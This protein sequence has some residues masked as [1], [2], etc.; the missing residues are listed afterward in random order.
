MEF[1]LVRMRRLRRTEALRRMVRETV[2]TPD[3]L[4]QPLFVVPGTNVKK[5]VTSMPGV[6]QL[7]V[8]HAVTEA[9]RARDAG[10]PAVILFGIPE[11]KDPEGSSSWNSSGIVQRATRAIKTELPGMCVIADVCF[12]EYTDHGHCGVVHEGDVDNDE[13]LENLAKQAVSLADAGVDVIAPSGMMDGM[14]GAI[15]DGLDEEGFE[16]VPIMSYAVKFASAFYGPFRD[17]AESAPA[18]GDRRTYQMDPANGREALREAALDVAEG[19]DIL[20]VKPALAYLDILRDLREEHDLPLA[21][22]NVSGEMAMLEAAA[23]KGWIERRRAILET[24]LSIRRAG[25]D[26]ILSYWATEAAGWLR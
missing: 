21:A 25:A 16:G 10:V 7:S 3:N 9:K 17:A 13:T 5:P 18:F 1:P 15:R 23:A 14:V 26:M 6:A 22:Y 8:E 11:R 20:M 2:L 24:L 12:C 4:I 19:A